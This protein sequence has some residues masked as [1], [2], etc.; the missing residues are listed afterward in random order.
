MAKKAKNPRPSPKK[1]A[2]Q[3]KPR[4]RD[5]LKL[6]TVGITP[7]GLARGTTAARLDARFANRATRPAPEELAKLPWLRQDR[8]YRVGYYLL[9]HGLAEHANHPEI[10][11]CNVPGAFVGRAHGLLNELADM[12]LNNGSVFE[13][14]QAILLGEDPLIVVGVRE[15]KPGQDKGNDHD[16]RVLRLVF[17]A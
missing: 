9:T 3:R 16:E 13:H 5:V 15:M 8:A 2:N 7:P 14:G 11:I 4:R 1:S 12:V 10:E 6:I 17:L